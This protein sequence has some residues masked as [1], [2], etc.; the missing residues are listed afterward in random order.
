M[1]G[2]SQIGELSDDMSML[3]HQRKDVDIRLSELEANNRAVSDALKLE[4]KYA[5]ELE[6]KLQQLG[7]SLMRLRRQAG[8][9]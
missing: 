8:A 5:G 2:E 3:R 1:S 4:T 6:K 7:A 9:A